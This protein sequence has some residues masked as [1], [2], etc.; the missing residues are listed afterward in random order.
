MKNASNFPMSSLKS[1]FAFVQM[2]THTSPS[3]SPAVNT[4]C[5]TSANL[6]VYRVSLSCLF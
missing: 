3:A 1:D 4:D 6:D 2:S 5:C